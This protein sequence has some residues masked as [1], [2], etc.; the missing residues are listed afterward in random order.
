MLQRLGTGRLLTLVMVAAVALTAAVAL[1]FGAHAD[2]T[3][4]AVPV[5][6]TPPP[7]A[8]PEPLAVPPATS[9]TP[10]LETAAPL[11]TPVVAIP[12]ALDPLPPAKTDFHF[13]GTYW[14]G[15]DGVIRMSCDRAQ[16]GRSDC[17]W[18]LAVGRG[19][20]LNLTL[21]WTGTA[22]LGL[23]VTSAE[24]TPLAHSSNAVGP[25]TAKLQGTPAQ[26]TVTVS[27]PEGTAAA[28]D[29]T[30]SNHA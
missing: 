12:P 11:P 2:P 6:S 7:A 29:L 13:S 18:V 22:T 28:F 20:P 27:V 8:E 19:N 3:G 5:A 26:V 23:G 10:G 21:A 14:R 24:G 4:S 1:G 15:A 16:V 25:L 9:G 17:S 30:I